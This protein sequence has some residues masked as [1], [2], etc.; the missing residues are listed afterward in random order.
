MSDFMWDKHAQVW[1]TSRGTVG[2]GWTPLR[3][4]NVVK[5]PIR[6]EGRAES[7]RVYKK[8]GFNFGGYWI[9][10]GGSFR[11]LAFQARFRKLR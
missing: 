6:D 2:N 3:Y 8:H 11:F 5:M 10:R 7:R 4:Y 1:Y 9:S